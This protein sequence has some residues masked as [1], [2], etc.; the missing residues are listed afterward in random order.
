MYKSEVAREYF[1]D[2]RA[3]DLI[4]PTHDSSDVSKSKSTSPKI[5]RMIKTTTAGEVRV[6]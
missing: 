2:V 1:K 4:M 3:N 5:T 6:D